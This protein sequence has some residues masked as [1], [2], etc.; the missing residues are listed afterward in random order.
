M[1]HSDIFGDFYKLRTLKLSDFNDIYSNLHSSK[2]IMNRIGLSQLSYKDSYLMSLNMYLNK[3]IYCWI[4]SDI[5]DTFYG[6]VTVHKHCDFYTIN[7]ILKPS[8]CGKNIASQAV[9]MA[10]FNFEPHSKFYAICKTY[11]ER[12]INFFTKLGFKY[13]YT[14]K[15]ISVYEVKVKWYQ[16]IK[17]H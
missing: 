15:F 7:I 5:N 11:N 3:N 2:S 16:C 13:A 1:S 8:A 14:D 10:I 12:G 4:V 9:R 6:I 17:R